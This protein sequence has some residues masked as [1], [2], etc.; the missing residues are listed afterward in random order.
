MKCALH[1]TIVL[2]HA[3]LCTQYIIQY[4]MYTGI[5]YIN[6]LHKSSVTNLVLSSS[7]SWA[8]TT[9]TSR[10]QTRS[11]VIGAASKSRTL[12][13]APNFLSITK[14]TKH[15]WQFTKS[16]C[17][18]NVVHWCKCSN[19]LV[20]VQWCSGQGDGSALTESQVR[21]R[22]CPHNRSIFR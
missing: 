5:L 16:F 12:T 2:W 6:Y 10:F 3:I 4:S 14:C 15:L 22:A 11:L 21:M 9:F 1:R 19:A 8:L 13:G 20:H 7:S 18:L 17:S